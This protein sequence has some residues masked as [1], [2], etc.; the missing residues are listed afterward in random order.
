M[1]SLLNIGVKAPGMMVELVKAV[2]SDEWAA[3]L[4][5]GPIFETSQLVVFVVRRLLKT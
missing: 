1:D 4:G 5:Y 3:F 2:H